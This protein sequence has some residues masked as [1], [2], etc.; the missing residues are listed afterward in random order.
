MIC[1]WHWTETPNSSSEKAVLELSPDK[2]VSRISEEDICMQ[3]LFM[4]AVSE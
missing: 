2:L 4:T 3:Y 1:Q